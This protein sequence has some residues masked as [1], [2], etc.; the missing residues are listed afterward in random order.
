MSVRTE[1]VGKIEDLKVGDRVRQRTGGDAYVVVSVEWPRGPEAEPAVTAVRT[2]G[3]SN[4]IEWERVLDS[5]F[6]SV[7]PA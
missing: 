7:D 3:V 6:D 1:P 2:I 5:G 4:P